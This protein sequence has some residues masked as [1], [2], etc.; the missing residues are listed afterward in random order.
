MLKSAAWVLYLKKKHSDK[1]R[2]IL[3]LSHPAGSSG[4]DGISKLL[5]SLSYMKVQAMVRQILELSCG[6]F[7]AKTDIDSAFRNVSVHPHDRPLLGMIWN[8][9]LYIDSVLPF[10]L[11]SAPKNF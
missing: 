6:C 11:I 3:D 2:L 7:L 5:C 10:G 1:W 8:Q 4:N 9:Q